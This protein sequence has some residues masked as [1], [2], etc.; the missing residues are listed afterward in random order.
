MKLINFSKFYKNCTQNLQKGSISA[1]GTSSFNKEIFKDPNL[2]NAY[3]KIYSELNSINNPLK[4]I[5]YRDLFH[6]KLPEFTSCDRASWPWDRI[7]S[8][9]IGP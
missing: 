5:L 3:K 4:K 8:S 9:S 2:I 1:D 7:K 6:C